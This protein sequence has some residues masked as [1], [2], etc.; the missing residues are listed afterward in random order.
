[1]KELKDFLDT[2][3]KGKEFYVPVIDLR[4]AFQD[5]LLDRGIYRKVTP[6]MFTRCMSELGYFKRRFGGSAEYRPYVF[7]FISLEERFF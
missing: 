4:E 6:N 1:M 5:Y 2:F 7:D 3:K